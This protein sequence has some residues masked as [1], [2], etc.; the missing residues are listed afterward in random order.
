MSQYELAKRS[1]VSQG[2]ISAILNG[3]KPNPSVETIRRISFALGVRMSD[4]IDDDSQLLDFCQSN[5]ITFEE[6]LQLS[7][8]IS[9][10]ARPATAS[11][12][13]EIYE[14]MR[15]DSYPGLAGFL[16]KSNLAWRDV[17][18]LVESLA[19]K[20][21]PETVEGWEESYTWYKTLG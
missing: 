5:D 12:W 18:S 19:G 13:R 15:V 6:Y 3:K 20:G 8:V 1:G 2:H 4:I 9:E 16:R 11:G 14:R 21:L 17:C 7:N 10:G